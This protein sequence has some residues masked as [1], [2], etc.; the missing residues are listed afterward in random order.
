MKIPD[1][2]TKEYFLGD[3]RLNKIF[4]LLD[5]HYQGESDPWGMDLD[6]MKSYLKYL[7]PLYDKYFQVRVFGTENIDPDQNYM[8][9]SNHTGQI[10]FDGMLISMATMLELEPPRI[11]RGMI[12]RWMAGLP[13]VGSFSAHAGS[14]LGD[15]E[16]C[17]YLLEKKESI[18]VFPEGV[19]GISK[20]T[21]DF[22]E[23]GPFTSGF[24]RLALSN[25][26]N[27][28]PV[29]VVGAE[30]AYPF[31]YQAKS[32]AKVLNL[33]ALPLSAGFL[34]GPLGALPLPSP[35]DIY[36]GAPYDVPSDL[37]DNSPDKE[38]DM[39]VKRVK[40][41]INGMLSAGLKT[42]RPFLEKF[43]LKDKRNLNQ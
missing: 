22:Y 24:F 34:L 33:P 26:T 10:A 7:Y 40:E 8:F 12:E 42:R 18:L 23:M 5:E 43:G 17:Q 2:F 38:V 36:F 25:K 11:V 9:T 28:L 32:L 20:N 13:F 41:Q 31:V 3:K 14:I 16:N 1:I 27:I 15:R 19:N 6:K 39:H 37:S 4:S 21:E 30:E 29:A 35:I